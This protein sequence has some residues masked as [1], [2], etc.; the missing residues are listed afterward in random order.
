VAV[1]TSEA[2]AALCDGKVD[3]LE[4]ETIAVVPATVA[5]QIQNLVTLK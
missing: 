2:M 1:V 4:A 3:F 5:S